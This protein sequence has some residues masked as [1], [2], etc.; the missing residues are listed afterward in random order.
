[1]TLNLAPGRKLVGADREAAGT[2]AAELYAAGC[3]I[4]SVA[5]QLGR[6]YGGTRMLLL[7][8]GVTLRTRGGGR[9]AA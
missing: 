6:S 1:M 2:R 9:T 8:A 5:A 4:R 7:D 3:T